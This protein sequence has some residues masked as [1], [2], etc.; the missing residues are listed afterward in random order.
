MNCYFAQDSVSAFIFSINSSKNNYQNNLHIN[1][2]AYKACS[3]EYVC[4][5]YVLFDLI[6]NPSLNSHP[7]TQRSLWSDLLSSP[8]QWDFGFHHTHHLILFS[9]FNLSYQWL[10]FWF[11]DSVT[12]PNRY[13]NPYNF[14][15][16]LL[17]FPIF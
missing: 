8:K 16:S 1:N 4:M 14:S 2:H 17:P 12:A 10:N 9:P 6:T 11:I 7:K 15:S 5:Y 13:F 3:A